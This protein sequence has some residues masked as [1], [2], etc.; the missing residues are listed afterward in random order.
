M[1]EYISRAEQL[2]K[3]LNSRGEPNLKFKSE[4]Q[5][6]IEKG[7]CLISEG[8]DEDS[9]GNLED[10]YE[11]YTNAVEVFLKIVIE[12]FRKTFKYLNPL[13]YFE[14]SQTETS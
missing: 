13:K 10:A 2:K 14:C 8:I 4:S 1:N 6:E 7:L 12:F 11:L 5:R 9:E 3:Q